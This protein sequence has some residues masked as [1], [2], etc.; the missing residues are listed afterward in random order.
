MNPDIYPVSL[1][2]QERVLSLLE[3]FA[4][5]LLWQDESASEE[6]EYRS[7]T[8]SLYNFLSERYMK[9]EVMF[10]V[11]HD[12]LSSLIEHSNSSKVGE[13][14]GLISSAGRGTTWPPLRGPLICFHILLVRSQ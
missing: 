6:E 8:D 7:I 2:P 11:A 5:Y 12:L 1:F 9:P 13:N 3:Q 14:P 4:A 10:M